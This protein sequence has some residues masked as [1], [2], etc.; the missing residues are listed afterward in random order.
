MMIADDRTK[1]LT[2]VNH[3]AF[4]KMISLKDQ[5][6]RLLSIKLEKDQQDVLLLC[7]VEQNSKAFVYRANTS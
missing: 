2:L 6:E 5:G 1:A 3:K 7:R 4:I